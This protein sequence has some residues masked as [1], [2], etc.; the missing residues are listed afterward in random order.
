MG[1]CLLS[2][3]RTCQ[4][5]ELLLTVW[6]HQFHPKLTHFPVHPLFLPLCG[7]LKPKGHGRGNQ[8]VWRGLETFPCRQEAHSLVRVWFLC[9]SGFAHYCGTGVWTCTWWAPTCKHL[10]HSHPG[11]ECFGLGQNSIFLMSF[12]LQVLEM[13]SLPLGILWFKLIR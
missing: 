11:T 9:R 6:V 7:C 8:R 13:A 5:L 2:E 12:Q 10:E 4:M 1:G 3:R